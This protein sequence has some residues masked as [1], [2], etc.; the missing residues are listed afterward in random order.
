MRHQQGGCGNGDGRAGGANGGDPLDD[1]PLASSDF[2]LTF[3][4]FADHLLQI[5][6][7][8]CP[9]D[10]VI[11]PLGFESRLHDLI[12]LH[13]AG[14]SGDLMR[15]GIAVQSFDNG[16]QLCIDVVFVVGLHPPI[17]RA[18]LALS[19]IPVNRV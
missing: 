2:A 4:H 15:A 7:H 6:F 3:S 1:L 19:M 17:L 12:D 5:R 14:V 13:K 18:T 9:V 10:F 11:F 8:L 16:L